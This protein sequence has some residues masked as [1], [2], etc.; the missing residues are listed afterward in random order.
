MSDT[1]NNGRIHVVADMEPANGQDFPLMQDHHILMQD[2]SRLDEHMDTLNTNT[3]ELI[4]TAR[5]DIKTTII[6]KIQEE[7]ESSRAAMDGIS[8]ALSKLTLAVEALDDNDTPQIQ[9]EDV[10]EKRY[11]LDESEVTVI[12]KTDNGIIM[13]L[14]QLYK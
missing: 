13:I 4:N 14:V 1:I 9:Y 3:E 10:D 5:D 12:G 2:G 11:P 8:S 7:S 6:S